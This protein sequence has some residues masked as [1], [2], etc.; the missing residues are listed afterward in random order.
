MSNREVVTSYFLIT[1][2]DN[3]LYKQHKKSGHLSITASL[4]VTPTGFKPVT[5]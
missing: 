3:V 1:H 2:E 5:A 4:S